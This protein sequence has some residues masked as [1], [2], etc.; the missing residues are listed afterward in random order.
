[1]DITSDWWDCQ[2]DYVT[3]NYLTYIAD[4]DSDASVDAYWDYI[5]V[6]KHVDSEPRAGGLCNFSRRKPI[7]ITSAAALSD[8]QVKFTV[9]YDTDM[10]PDFDD[11]RFTAAD[12]TPLS[13]WIEDKTDNVNADV[14]VNVS[15][16]A[17][18]TTTIH[19][20]YGDPY[21]MAGSDGTATFDLFD[22]FSGQD[23]DRDVWGTRSTYSAH[24]VDDGLDIY[25]G[26]IYT[27]STVASTPQNR[28]IE[29]L[30]RYNC[31]HQSYS[32]L[33]IADAQSASDIGNSDG[34]ALVYAMTAGNNNPEK[35]RIWADDGTTTGCDIASNDILSTPT[36]GTDYIIGYSFR[37]ITDISCFVKDTAYTDIAR[38]TYVGTWN[39]PFYLW[40]GYYYGG[41]ATTHNIDDLGVTWVRVRKYAAAEPTATFGGEALASPAG[42]WWDGSWAHRTPVELEERSGTDLV[43]YPVKITIDTPS[44]IADGLVQTD[45]SD[46]R[47]IDNNGHEVSWTPRIRGRSQPDVAVNLSNHIDKKSATQLASHAFISSLDH[48]RDDRV[49]LATYSH[50]DPADGNDTGIQESYVCQGNQWEGYFTADATDAEPVYH[51]SLDWADASDLDLYLYD[52]VTLLDS[53][54]TAEKPEQVAGYLTAGRTYRVVVNGTS[55]VGNDTRFTIDVSKSPIQAMCTY[56]EGGYWPDY[57]GRNISQYRYWTGSEWTGYGMHDEGEANPVEGRYDIYQTVIR[58]APTRN[59]S[60]LGTIDFYSDLNVQVWNG[61]IWGEVLELSTSTYNTR[62]SFDIAYEQSSERAMVVYR[63]NSVPNPD[64]PAYALWDGTGWMHGSVQSIGNH[65]LIQVRLVPDPGS[66]EIMLVTMDTD[67]DIYAQVW[68]GSAWGNVQMLTGSGRTHE[69]LCFDA[70]YE[71]GT[72]E[73]VVV[74]GQTGDNIYYRKWDGA[75]WDAGS[76]LISTTGHAPYWIKLA[77]DPTSNQIL[78]GVLDSD[79]DINVN[80]WNGAGW[81]A[82]ASAI[83]VETVASY[84]PRRS[85]DVAFEQNSGEGIVAWGDRTGTPKYRRWTGAGWGAE[86]SASDVGSEYIYWVRLEP[87]MGSDEIFLVTSDCDNDLNIQ[88]WNGAA[89]SA[90]A[91]VETQSVYGTQWEYGYESFGIASPT[92]TQTMCVYYDYAPNSMSDVPRYKLWDGSAW[93]GEY[94]ANPVCGNTYDDYARLDVGRSLIRASPTTSEFILGTLDYANDVN[95][96]IWEDTGWSS[97]RVL[98]N[99]TRH[100]RRALDIAYE[101]LSGRAMVVYKGDCDTNVP[102]YQIWDGSTSTW[103]GGYVNSSVGDWMAMNRVDRLIPKPG[104]NEMLLLTMNWH[105]D[106]YAQIWN[107]S[108]WGDSHLITATARTSS[109]Q[110]FDAAYEYGTG[111]FVVVWSEHNSY[112]VRYCTYN[113]TWSAHTILYDESSSDEAFWIKLA[114]DPNSSRIIMGALDDARDIN[115]SIWDGSSWSAVTEVEDDAPGDDRRYFDVAF[116]QVSGEAM[117]AWSD[118]TYTPKYRI[119]DGSWG[120]ETSASNIG[121]YTR[122]VRLEPDSISDEIF[123]MT[124]DRAN[125]INIQKWDGSEWSDAIELETRS[126][127]GYECFDITCRD[128]TPVAT[129]VNWVEWRAQTDNHLNTSI[130]GFDPINS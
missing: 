50:R 9:A 25:T 19:M 36:L 18:G 110:C 91:E 119:W 11:L 98:S 111:E 84:Y 73:V 38:N 85:F 39:D 101:Q 69:Y 48:D 89:W 58:S 28:T 121:Y 3:L 99:T 112:D 22:D 24:S 107:G 46:I 114:S 88:K 72:G 127:Y 2:G 33:C 21:A 17:A 104:T 79:Y 94:E 128:T 16:I 70:A 95:V 113:G 40:L 61:S 5:Y 12:G 34:N 82:A 14:W 77:S 59:E 90:A 106:L 63:N 66:D 105:N 4:D 118:D 7:T 122:W 115:V 130:G 47:I 29:M 54:E 45:L 20:Y 123:L 129:T 44:M 125:D 117:I 87:D 109:Y 74:W 93:S 64:V 27:K 71:Y 92:S 68:N 65:R 26:S 43:A 81:G 42:A 32:G 56:Y 23:L 86:Q 55:V 67:L 124:S 120:N 97:P 13:Y 8:Y 37:G 53:S 35:I 30:A 83:E 6:R 80:I 41:T 108:A 1:M 116:E 76:T 60:I 51:F 49:G 100:D 62:K 52:G 96:Q 78:M 15:S 10:Q 75:N 31:G 102:E 57:I 126:N 103:T